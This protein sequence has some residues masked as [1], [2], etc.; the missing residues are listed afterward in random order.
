MGFPSIVG[1]VSGAAH[2]A[3]DPH[4]ALGRVLLLDAPQFLP[5]VVERADLAGADRATHHRCGTRP[6]GEHALRGCAMGAAMGKR[7]R[8][9]HRASPP[10]QGPTAATDR[11]DAYARVVV[12][13]IARV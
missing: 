13:L 7:H 6:F 9:V 3:A 11:G 10:G 4:G 8:H 2:G 12:T 1:V 5:Y